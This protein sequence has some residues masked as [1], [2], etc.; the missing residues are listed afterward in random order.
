MPTFKILA[1]HH[2]WHIL[3]EIPDE[4]VYN[5]LTLIG[6][7]DP[8]EPFSNDLLKV[9]ADN[10]TEAWEKCFKA[11]DQGSELWVGDYVTHPY[12]GA[13]RVTA[14]NGNMVTIQLQDPDQGTC[15]CLLDGRQSVWSKI[16]EWNVSNEDILFSGDCLPEGFTWL[17][18]QGNSHELK[19]MIEV[20]YSR[21]YGSVCLGIDYEGEPVVKYGWLTDA[22]INLFKAAAVAT[23]Q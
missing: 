20:N 8:S 2:R 11:L 23:F 15:T 16:P 10:P 5:E 4:G 9:S 7:V 21:N 22:E 6:R 17:D 1:S 3:C 19:G 14:I 13:G 12:R 18:E